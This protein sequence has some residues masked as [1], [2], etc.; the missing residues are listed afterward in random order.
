MCMSVS[1]LISMA[2]WLWL[3]GSSCISFA[4]TQMPFCGLYSVV[5][6]INVFNDIYF[7]PTVLIFYS[8]KF[9]LV[10]SIQVFSID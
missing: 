9:K 5:L 4:V 3:A 7:S 1:N 6:M 2:G 8:E 10:S